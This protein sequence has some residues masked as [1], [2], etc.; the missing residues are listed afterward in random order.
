MNPMQ[1]ISVHYSNLS[2]AEKVTCDLI[3]KEPQVIIDN[4]IAEAAK[5]YQVSPSSI[6]RMTKRLGYKGYSEFRYAMEGYINTQEIYS[7]NKLSS[8]IIDSY[9]TALNELKTSFD[10]KDMFEFI[11]MIDRKNVFTVGIGNSS[12]P[13]NQFVYSMYVEGKW[14][15]CIGDALK[16]KYLDISITDQDMVIIFSV[17]GNN[18]SYG[19]LC[20]EWKKKNIKTALIT[21]NSESKLINIVNYSFI[22]PTLPFTDLIQNNQKRYLDN[23]SLFFVFTD[24]IMSYYVHYKNKNNL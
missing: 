7:E 8:S 9:C 21:A 3:L 5:I 11:E 18:E 12:L 4:P 1:K 20:K 13:A 14:C 22:L 6:L 17:S 24:I 16:I 2:K 19:A 15:E 10:E 23:R